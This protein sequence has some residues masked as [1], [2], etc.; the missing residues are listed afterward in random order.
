MFQASI[1]NIPPAKSISIRI[2][3]VSEIKQDADENQVRF[4]LPTSIAPRYGSAPPAV[5]STSS[6]SASK[7]SVDISCAMAK[8]ITSI[9]SPSHTI[10][11]HLGTSPTR[12]S[13]TADSLL[14]RDLVIIVQAPELDAPR[15]FVERHP[16]DGT[17]AVSLTFSPRF[18]LNAVKSS[19]LIFLVDRS[20]SMQGSQIEQAGEALELFLRS[21]PSDD[22]YINII[23]FGSTHKALFPKSVDY[24]TYSLKESTRYAQA[25][26]ADM[27]GTEIMGAFQEVFQRRRH[28]VPTQIFLLT[29]GQI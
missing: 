8:Q 10:Q 17:H 4:V 15:A 7:L 11:V 24:S 21:I 5:S 18:A 2:T 26:R 1:G 3:L 16:T 23:G 22:H 28:D 9:Q 29:D 20:G 25:L 13:L 12:V 14:D 19:E 6:D 27:G